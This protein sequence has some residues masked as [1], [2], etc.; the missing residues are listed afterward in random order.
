MHEGLKAGLC[1]QNCIAGTATW[2]GHKINRHTRGMG[3]TA[4][5]LGSLCRWAAV[6]VT[7]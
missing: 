5:S 7:G 4:E 1:L 3:I 6:A 2:N